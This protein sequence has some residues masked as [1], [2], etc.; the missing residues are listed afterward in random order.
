[1]LTVMRFTS[2]SCRHLTI[3]IQDVTAPRGPVCG[4][5][6]DAPASL[7]GAQCSQLAMSHDSEGTRFSSTSSQR[8]G[9]PHINLMAVKQTAGPNRWGSSRRES[10]K[11]IDQT[12]PGVCFRYPHRRKRKKQDQLCM[13]W[14]SWPPLGPRGTGPQ[15]PQCHPPPWLSWW[16]GQTPGSWTRAALG[17]ASWVPAV[18]AVGPCCHCSG[19]SLSLVPSAYS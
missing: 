7:W 10:G 3:F 11:G 12:T 8:P 1:M 5:P 4:G 14:G 9:R 2:E 15:A 16:Q 18:T 19:S 6:P 13:M 17:V